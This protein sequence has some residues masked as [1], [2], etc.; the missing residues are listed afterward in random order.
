MLSV[1]VVQCSR[2]LLFYVY[3]KLFSKKLQ[4]L[5]SVLVVNSIRLFL[6]VPL[7]GTT[8]IETICN[9]HTRIYLQVVKTHILECAHSFHKSYVGVLFKI[10][11]TQKK[12]VNPTARRVVDRQNKQSLARS[13]MFT[14]GS[15]ILC[16]LYHSMQVNL[17][18]FTWKSCWFSTDFQI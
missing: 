16:S 5:M 2:N 11:L 15:Y 1:F 12:L 18:D 6:K 3:N 4:Y 9:I 10:S 17:I 7:I 8:R 14:A 13:P